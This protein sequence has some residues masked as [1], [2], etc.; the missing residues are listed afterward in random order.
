MNR[1]SNWSQHCCFAAS[2][3]LHR[4]LMK[5]HRVAQPHQSVL[6]R[7]PAASCLDW[8]SVLL[9]LHTDLLIWFCSSPEPDTNSGMIFILMTTL[10]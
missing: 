6:C 7:F 3:Y 1:T 10:L 2:M 9:R 5:T 8:S 4:T